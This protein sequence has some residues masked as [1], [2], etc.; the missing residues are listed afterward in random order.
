MNVHARKAPCACPR[1]L[2]ARHSDA[3]GFRVSLLAPLILA[4]FSVGISRSWAWNASSIRM[5]AVTMPTSD[6]EAVFAALQSAGVRYLVVG[7]VAVVL[8]GY[9]R[10]TAD[11]DLVVSLDREN[12]LGLVDALSTLGY[13]PREPVPAAALADAETRRLWIQEKDLTVFSFWS[14]GHPATEIDVFVTEPFP[15][16]PALARALRVQLGALTVPV[17]SIPDLIFLKRQSAR[18]KDLDDIQALE[19]ILAAEGSR[20]G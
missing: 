9:P 7:G 6:F 1:H 15:I 18:T 8:Q 2:G 3:S 5:K 14:P 12:L 13:R 10:F 19:A 4:P 17:A 20:D 11:L 16:E